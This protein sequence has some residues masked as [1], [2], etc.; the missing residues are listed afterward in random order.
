MPDLVFC[1]TQKDKA[2]LRLENKNLRGQLQSLRRQS[3]GSMTPRTVSLSLIPLMQ[4]LQTVAL[5]HQNCRPSLCLPLQSF[6]Q[7]RS[8]ST[9]LGRCEVLSS[10]MIVSAAQETALLMA[11]HDLH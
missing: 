10:I 6:Q 3:T 9:H 5:I 2:A 7:T 4:M 8:L 11:R 1:R